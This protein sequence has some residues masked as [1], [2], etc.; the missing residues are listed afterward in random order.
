MIQNKDDKKEIITSFLAIVLVL[1]L[2]L[3]GERFTGVL[4]IILGIIKPFI[5]GGAIAYVL[6]LPMSFIERKLLFFMK[7]KI[8]RLKRVFSILLSLV[9]VALL[10][11]LLFLTVIPEIVSAVQNIGR[12]VPI[13][14]ERLGAFLEKHLSLSA[15]VIPDLSE[16]IEDNWESFL[17]KLLPVLK[18]GI[19]TILSTTFSAA[20]VFVSSIAS[21]FVSLIFAIYILGDKER[22]G[23]QLGTLRKAYLKEET[24][25]R[26]DHY[27]SIL[28]KSF[29]SFITGQ[30]MEAVILGS[31]FMVVLS[32]LRMPYAV[33][34]GVVVMFSALLPIV[35]AFIACFI[36][37]F[38]ILLESPVKALVFVIV[39]LVVQQLENNLIYP[40]VVGSSV[41]LPS[42]WVFFAVT[43]GGSFFGVVGMLIFI[44]LVSTLYILIKEDTEKRIKEK[45]A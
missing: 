14:L 29:S 35:G 1:A 5:L 11:L 26:V 43:I 15:G 34:I 28:N 21:F 23:R 17:S 42:I 30:C 8:E 38:L 41:G 12:E 16:T 18:S 2:L 19:G 7:G 9:F 25:K 36:G 13:A 22:L 27:I 40:R 24:N 10:V 37:A 44:P 32:I 31:I 20:G 3:Y 4:G 39:F 33:M 45:G 6:S